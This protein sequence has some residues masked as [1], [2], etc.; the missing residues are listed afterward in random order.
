MAKTTE[1]DV[2]AAAQSLGIGIFLALLAIGVVVPWV[3]IVIAPFALLAVIPFAL[4]ILAARR[5]S[6]SEQVSG[7]REIV[8]HLVTYPNVIVYFPNREGEQEKD[9][10]E[11][12]PLR[13]IS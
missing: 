12:E 11:A 1:G 3:Y 2:E 5:L 9:V 6:Q 4:S 10:E 7:L 8:S 13:K